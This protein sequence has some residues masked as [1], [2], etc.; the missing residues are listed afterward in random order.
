MLC[1]HELVM[2]QNLSVLNGRRVEGNKHNIGFS[3]GDLHGRTMYNRGL[4]QVSIER[5]QKEI[6][7]LLA[8]LISIGYLMKN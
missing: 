5:F 1:F 6:L 2:G 3:M 4:Y 8:M 7:K